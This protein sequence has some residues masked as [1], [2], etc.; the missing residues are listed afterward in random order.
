MKCFCFNYSEQFFK[1]TINSAC[2]FELLIAIW[3]CG[4]NAQKD[5]QRNYLSRS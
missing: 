3:T 1:Y 4:E 2:A 5:G